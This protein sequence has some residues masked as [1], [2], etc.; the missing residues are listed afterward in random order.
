MV[1]DEN[2]YDRSLLEECPSCRGFGFV[3]KTAEDEDLEMCME[4]RGEGVIK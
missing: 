2:D 1:L 3:G 4:C